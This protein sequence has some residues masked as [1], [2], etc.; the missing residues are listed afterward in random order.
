MTNGTLAQWRET[1]Y[2][3]TL[4][5]QK[6]VCLFL[7]HL[8]MTHYPWKLLEVAQGIHYIHSEGVVHGSLR[9]VNCLYRNIV[10]TLTL[11]YQDNILLDADLHVQ[12]ADFGLTHHSQ[13]ATTRYNSMAPELF[14]FSE[15]DVYASDDA[16]ARMQKSDIYAFGFLYYEVSNNTNANALTK[17]E[18]R[19]FSHL[20]QLRQPSRFLVISF[21]KQRR[22]RIF[23][24]SVCLR[25]P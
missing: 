13:V 4:E 6:R 20:L 18:L 1:A 3:P 24:T 16:M 5:V 12:I 25:C 21:E 7:L 19:M 15:V 11:F 8:F 9:G 2:P 10:D 17:Y 23:A 22:N 14:E